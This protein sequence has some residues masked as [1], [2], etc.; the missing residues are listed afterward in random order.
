MDRDVQCV[1]ILL[2]NLLG[3]NKV[4]HLKENIMPLLSELVNDPK[5]MKESMD[6]ISNMELTPLS[7]EEPGPTISEV[8]ERI[9]SSP[10]LTDE[11][12][13]ALLESI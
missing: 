12:A 4:F 3:Y 7:W 13:K 5:L 11:D 6:R 1:I 2:L 10:G 9:K 8:C